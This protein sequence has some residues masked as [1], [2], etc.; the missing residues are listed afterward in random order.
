M[1]RSTSID[2]MTDKD[3]VSAFQSGD[4]SVFDA[5]VLKHQDLIF[6]LCCRILDDHHDAE[7]IAQETFVRA[8]EGLA[9]FRSESSLSTWLY[10][11]SVNLCKNKMGSLFNRMRHKF[12]P[13]HGDG[14]DKDEDGPGARLGTDKFSPDLLL[15]RKEVAELVS[16]AIARLPPDQKVVIVLADMEGRPYE[17]IAEILGEKI[18]TV[19]SRL[20][21]AREILKTELKEV[22]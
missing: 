7:E 1:N 21:R 13:L 17:E 22:F 6:G 12:L 11:I 9:K 16:S 8:Y 4:K 5:I 15:E 2:K 14:A 19:K 10:R 20:N 3:L 18:G